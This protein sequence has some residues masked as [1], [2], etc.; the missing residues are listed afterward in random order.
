MDSQKKTIQ[1]L[2]VSLDEKREGLTAFYRQ[3]GARLLAD[4]VEPKSAGA[5]D[6]ERADAWHSL[7][8]S[9]ESDTQTILDIQ[10]AVRR[11]QELNQFRKEL[12]RNKVEIAGEYRSRAAELG[13]AFY[14]G[15]TA[16]D[17]AVCG[18]VWKRVNDESNTLASLGERQ[19]RLKQEM[20]ISGFFAKMVA[21]FKLAGLAS[22][23]RQHTTR[24]Q[25][26]YADGAED[27]LRNGFLDGRRASGSLDPRI[28]GLLESV[29]AAS[30][31]LQEMNNREA[32]LEADLAAEADRLATLGAAGSP[33]QRIAELNARV[34]E[35][36]KRIDSLTVLSAQEYADKFIDE[37]GISTLGDTRD[38][39]T[40]S[41][42]GAYSHQLEQIAA[43][44]A[45]IVTIRRK[46][47][48]LETSVRI[49]SLDRNIANYSRSIE[50]Y[51]S[52]IEH[53][54]KLIDGLR[55][56][57]SAAGEDRMRL[58][59]HREELEKQ[60]G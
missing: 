11:Q 34:R 37:S 25:K 14:D 12:D 48:I 5:I 27:V 51:E 47:E 59:G 43:M 17:A 23:I 30:A 24:L 28:A 7:M 13:K 40:F 19:Q 60:Q 38:G 45:D 8:R 22:T 3:F 21:Q 2:T 57:I 35:T 18:E 58:V 42:M 33:Q 46:I 41:D 1:G 54:R 55:E 49:E 10:A 29:Q 44:R 52:K 6:R 53:Y 56:N 16:D 4:S 26:M 36:D 31:R 39:H 15:Y 32:S 20:D 50:D 9:R